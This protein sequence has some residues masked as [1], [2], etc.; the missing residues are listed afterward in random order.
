MEWPAQDEEPREDKIPAGC[1]G[2]PR[3]ALG[4]VSTAPPLAPPRP[5]PQRGSSPAARA[6]PC[7]LRQAQRR[8]R[9][10]RRLGLA[11]VGPAH[12]QQVGAVRAGGG[13]GGGSGPGGCRAALGSGAAGLAEH[14]GLQHEEAGIGRGHLLH[15]GRAGEAVRPGP[16]A[17]GGAPAAESGP[18]EKALAAAAPSPL[19]G[20]P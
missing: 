18:R 16:R 15:P 1:R 7:A 3:T 6:P 9:R 4:K 11:R 14:H 20:S 12:R 8:W 2:Q 19:R 17:A 10:W 13:G 5:A